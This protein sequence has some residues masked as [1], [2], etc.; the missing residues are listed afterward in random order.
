[1]DRLSNNTHVPNLMKFRP[2]GTELYADG[3]TDMTKL[4]VTF[5]NAPGKVI[6]ILIQSENQIKLYL[7]SIKLCRFQC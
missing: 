6:L 7:K 4:R 1:M 3:Q 2:V 5:R